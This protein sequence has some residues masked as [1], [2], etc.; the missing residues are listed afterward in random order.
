MWQS[1]I[2]LSGLLGKGRA[3]KIYESRKASTE[4]LLL[5]NYYFK[6]I[7]IQEV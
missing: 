2:V 7:G 3:K 1:R 5:Q 4:L 6:L